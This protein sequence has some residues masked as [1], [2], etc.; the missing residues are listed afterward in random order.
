VSL[1]WRLCLALAALAAVATTFMASMAYAAT[2]RRLGA[3]VDRFLVERLD[4]AVSLRALPVE[5]R[6]RRTLVEDLLA[7]DARL[8]I[9]DASGTP[10]DRAG[11]SE[12]PV[13]DADVALAASTGRPMVRLRTVSLDGRP[14]RLA[15][16]SLGGSGAVQLARSLAESRRLL[17]GLRWRLALVGLVVVGAAALVGE[18]I[19]RRLTRDL[20]TL[21]S[22]AEH[23]A[24]TGDLTIPVGDAATRADEV[25]RLARA[26]ATMLEA[27][28]RSRG[29][30]RALVQDASHELRTP[31]TSIRT[32][33]DVLAR[34]PDLPA[35]QRE[36]VVAELRLEMAELGTLLDEL[37]A[38]AADVGEAEEPRPVSL[39]A[40]ARQAAARV[41]R[42]HD[43]PIEVAGHGA[44]VSAPPLGLARAVSNLLE[45]AVK[46]SP[47]GSPVI[48]R[49]DDGRLAVSDAGPGVAAADADRIFDRFYR[50]ASSRTL[51]GSGLG[52]AI[53]RQVVQSAGGQVFVVPRPAQGAAGPVPAIG[54]TLPVVAVGPAPDGTGG[55]GDAT[56]VE[57]D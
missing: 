28:G 40:V 19:A 42:R 38:T 53:V 49:L 31:V 41:G 52:L 50:S 43:R 21:T 55:V 34:H 36:A 54:F 15:T 47:P 16:G 20:E 7:D 51:P 18:R 5:G 48:V 23:V 9:L 17:D 12:L 22:A 56:V 24:G 1:R 57:S 32:N 45:N 29:Q 39:D 8:Q 35:A 6:R 26:M 46:F 4:V 2:S 25:G 13:D 33:I 3:E 44:M 11:T 14:Y 10:L 27:L 37:V 30:Q